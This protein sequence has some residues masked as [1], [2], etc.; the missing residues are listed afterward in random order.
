LAITADH[1][2]QEMDATM[3]QTRTMTIRINGASREFV[4]TSVGENGRDE[5]VSEYCV[6]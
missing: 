6:T 5:N 2:I 4:A 3:R 1:E